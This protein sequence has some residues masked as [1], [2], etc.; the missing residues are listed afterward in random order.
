M[1]SARGFLTRIRR[2]IFRRQFES[3]MAE[4]MHSHI[5]AETQRRIAAGEDPATANRLAH[6]EF[7]SVDARKEE[8]RDNRLGATLGILVGGIPY[9]LR[10]LKRSRALTFVGLLTLA[11][12]IG[13]NTSMLTLLDTLVFRSSPYPDSDRIVIIGSATS[14]REFILLSYQDGNEIRDHGQS[15]EAV[16]TLQYRSEA[17]SEPGLPTQQLTTIHATEDLF[18][19]FGIQPFI[20]R[21]FTAEEQTP[22]K[23]QVAV[24]SHLFWQQRFDGNPNTVGQSVRING[25]MVE[26]IGI[27]PPVSSEQ[28]AMR[29][30]DLWRPMGF[31]QEIITNRDS[32]HFVIYARLNPGASVE[33][34]NAELEPLAERWVQ[35]R[36]KYWTD[37]RLRVINFNEAMTNNQVNLY[38]WML[39]GLSGFVLLLAC[40][41]LTNL[42][43]ARATDDARSLAIRSALGASR[44]RLIA[45]Q[46][47]QSLTLATIGGGLGILL[48]VWINQIISSTMQTSIGMNTTLSLNPH[49]LGVAA[50]ISGLSGIL[51][52]L[53]PA[54]VA[55]RTRITNLINQQSHGSKSGHHRIRN[56]LIV[57]QV[58]LALILLGGAGVMIRS[59][60]ASLKRDSGWDTDQI[61][62]AAIQLPVQTVY[63]TVEKKRAVIE[64]FRQRLKRI[65]G[66]EHTAVSARLPTYSILSRNISIGDRPVTDPSDK[67]AAGFLLV[68]PEFFATM[69]I[70]LIDGKLFDPDVRG[71][72]PSQVIINQTMA[73][74]FWPNESAIGK[75]MSWQDKDNFITA[76]IVGVVADIS[77]PG[78]EAPLNAPL[79]Y[80]EPFTQNPWGRMSLLA[81]GPNPAAFAADMRK[82]IDEV[83]PD[84]A[85]EIFG[86]IED[87]LLRGQ[88][89]LRLIGGVMSWFAVLGLTLASIGLYGVI[90]HIVAQRTGEFGIRMALGASPGNVLKLVLRRGIKLT[91]I[92]I[93][94]GLVGAFLLN[95]LLRGF[96]P[97]SVSADPITLLGTAIMLFVVSLIACWLPARRATKV[98][99]VESLRTE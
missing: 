51:F 76:E 36:P 73:Q 4:E 8:V 62:Q 2:V 64:E 59:L 34:A 12:G 47:T 79:Q 57:F 54:L 56:S 11:L 49:L 96:L 22:G 85:V 68:T 92:G 6:A 98:N 18:R 13:V 32:K 44:R 39:F 37:R 58:A 53:V 48:A 46:L 14:K 71:D 30:V 75:Q 95:L 15:F 28:I 29:P 50:G 7:G 94:I 82:I 87:T 35:D 16:T 5:E 26:I 45:Q 78:R 66:A 67:I 84:A 69:G 55:S 52:G 74:R 43:L 61:F 31:P 60:N 83:N 91:L 33:G 63:N 21:S 86:T 90:S 1:S 89:P 93:G 38:V 70:S 27:M 19:T 20:G 10:S 41:N 97:R 24:L 9:A 23:N 42:Q 40:A 99:P 25:E 88:R 65:P 17:L 72:G 81:R 77:Y 80:Y 3:E